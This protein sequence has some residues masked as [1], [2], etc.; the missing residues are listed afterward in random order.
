[1]TK[2]IT[3]ITLAVSLLA[4]VATAKADP[5]YGDAVRAAAQSGQLTPHGVFDGR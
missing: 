2:L 1:M 4:G 3:S 5:M